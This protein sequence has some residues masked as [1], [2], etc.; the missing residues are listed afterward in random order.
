MIAAIG[1]GV[2]ITVGV[3]PLL[4]VGMLLLLELVGSVGVVAGVGLL[5]VVSV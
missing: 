1:V 2:G 3:L 5:V 4:T